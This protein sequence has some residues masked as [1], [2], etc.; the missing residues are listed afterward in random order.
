MN[1][2]TID[3][4]KKILLRY[5]E[6]IDDEIKLFFD[7]YAN[8]LLGI[9]P[10]AKEAIQVL[11]EFCSRPGKRL[12]GTLAWY[13]YDQLADYPDRATGAKIA[14]ALELIQNYLL[15]VDDVMDR[16]VIRRG[17]P[18]VHKYYEKRLANLPDHSH[19]SEM[20]A[21]NVGL[22]AQHLVNT[23]IIDTGASSEQKLK[24]LKL[25]N[26][27][28][29]LTCYG[30]IDDLLHATDLN[31]IKEEEIYSI[32]EAKSSYY[33][34]INPIQ[35]GVVLAGETSDILM[36]KIKDFGKPAGLAFQI[37]DDV[38]GIYGDSKITGKPNIDDLRE[39]KFTLLVLNTYQ[40]TD[41]AGRKNLLSVLGNK[42]VTEADAGR[43]GNLM[44]KCGAKQQVINVANQ[45]AIEAKGIISQIDEINEDAKKFFCSIVDY[46]IGRAR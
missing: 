11:R 35:M 6:D 15:I 40:N 27:N 22:L 36:D 45:K 18:T 33:T 28:I 5:K 38:L 19:L 30:Q 7:D 1:T 20:M 34:F 43:I 12:R 4:A 37:A 25:M 42:N 9:S 16:S 24:A 13:S 8:N 23:L 10:N 31:A 26:N 41:A 29:S 32:Y 2:D 44:D 46:S 14:I 21:I 17:G 3:S 39:G